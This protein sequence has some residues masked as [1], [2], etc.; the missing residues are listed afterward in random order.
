[1]GHLLILSQLSDI[2]QVLSGQNRRLHKN[3]NLP[4]WDILWTL[5]F[6]DIWW[7][8]IVLIILLNLTEQ[9]SYVD[10]RRATLCVRAQ[11]LHWVDVKCNPLV[12]TY[13]RISFLWV[14]FEVELVVVGPVH[15][16][17]ALLKHLKSCMIYLYI[18]IF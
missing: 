16:K 7:N 13:R 9:V 8:W 12:V 3:Q 14:W 18:F 1:M 5:I 15:Q 6:S 4:P 11:L 2:I 10:W 17:S